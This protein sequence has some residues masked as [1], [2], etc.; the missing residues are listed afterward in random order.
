LRRRTKIVPRDDSPALLK[1]RLVPAVSVL[2]TPRDA[3][4]ETRARARQ[5][6]GLTFGNHELVIALDGPNDAEFAFWVKEFNLVPTKR[7]AT[8]VLKSADVRSAYESKDPIRLVVILLERAGQESALNAAVNAAQAPVLALFDVDA[9]FQT[10]VLLRLIRPMLDDPKHT[11][12]V[13]GV[14]AP[15]PSGALPDRL[16]SLVFLRMWLSRCSAFSDWNVLVPVPGSA[17]LVYRDWAI[18]A[19]GF[20][21]GVLDFFLRL[22]R[23]ARISKQP[24][25]IA[26]VPNALCRLKPPQTWDDVRN[27]VTRDQRDSGRIILGATSFKWWTAISFFWIRLVRPVAECVAYLMMIV[28]LL[29]GWIDWHLAFLVLLSTIGTGL[30]LS[31]GAVSLRELAEYHGSDPARLSAM[32]FASIPENLWFRH[33]RNVWMITAFGKRV[34]W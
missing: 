28:G 23:A 31:M 24:Y 33:V 22:H 30:L 11:I 1:S 20:K 17:M 12:A 5:L 18:K 4:D 16:F 19:D 13:C 27:L 21:D 7:P 2:F 8:G 32:F 26:F 10:D 29:F 14:E 6:I 15:P 34:D 3:S 25:R 9:E